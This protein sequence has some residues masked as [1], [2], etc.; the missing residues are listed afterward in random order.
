MA[1]VLGIVAVQQ[2]ADS[3][4]TPGGPQGNPLADTSLTHLR[5]T[6]AEPWDQTQQADPMEPVASAPRP[7]PAAARHPANIRSP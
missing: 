3:G 6:A 1:I 4:S 5:N 2:T 7:S